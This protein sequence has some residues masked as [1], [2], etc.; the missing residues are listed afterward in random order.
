MIEMSSEI[1]FHLLPGLDD[2]PSSIEQA[3]ELAR[4]AVADGTR[5]IVATPH[6]NG[7]FDIDISSLPEQVRLVSERLRR[8]RVPVRV[9]C[10]GELA[11]ERVDRLSQAELKSI[12]Q[13]PEGR[14]W[15]LLEAPLTGLD[16]MFAAAATELR[17]RGFGIVVAHPERSLGKAPSHWQT[18][19]REIQAGSGLQ[20]TAWSLAGLHGEW[21]RTTAVRLL[22]TAS[23]VAVSSDAHGGDRV[24][25]LRLANDALTGLGARNPRRFTAG[26]PEMLLRRG[27]R[28]RSRALAA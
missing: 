25:A 20:L 11:P 13:G 7:L 23:L 19:E 14:Q 27:L 8:E 24:P 12:A 16:G 21:A 1:H 2:G 9:L 17:A 10:G 28:P 15:L 26:V 5:T 6:V 4:M 18:L 3:V 22:R